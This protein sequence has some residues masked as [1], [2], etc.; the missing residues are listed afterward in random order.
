[1]NALPA[2][3][4]HAARVRESLL[5]VLGIAVAVAVLVLF[6]YSWLDSRKV[7]SITFLATPHAQIAI[8]VRG[9]IS[10]PGVVYLEPGARLI[11]VVNSSGGLAPNAD[12]SLVNLSSRVLDGQMII[13]PTQVPD[14]ESTAG[15]GLININSASAAELKELPGIGDVLAERI[16]AYRESNGPF[17]TTDQLGNVEGI[18]AAL[19]ESLAPHISV[20]GND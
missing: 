12:Q 19:V 8:D 4:E 10:T 18:S 15:S 7:P 13:I 5:V 20:S 17:Q 2:I 14:G 6:T 1:M 9:A 16:V 3:N 11:D